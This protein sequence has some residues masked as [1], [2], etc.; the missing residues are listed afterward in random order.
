MNVSSIAWIS[1]WIDLLLRGHAA[2]HHAVI[3]CTLSLLRMLEFSAAFNKMRVLQI[4][5]PEHVMFI[6]LC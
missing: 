6:D 4:T 1:Q 5:H 2:Q 3:V